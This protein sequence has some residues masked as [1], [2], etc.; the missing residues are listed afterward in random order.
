MQRE[1]SQDYVKS[2]NDGSGLRLN[3]VT[4]SRLIAKENADRKIGEV[5]N[6]R[7]RR[8]VPDTPLVQFVYENYEQHITNYELL[9][10]SGSSILRI[11]NNSRLKRMQ[12]TW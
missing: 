5:S 11:I 1:H 8:Y 7:G 12:P 3:N 2:P 10:V 9:F 6:W 4:N